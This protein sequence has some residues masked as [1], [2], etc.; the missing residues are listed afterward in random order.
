MKVNES[1]VSAKTVGIPFRDRQALL[2]ITESSTRGAT[3]SH[4]EEDMS[5]SHTMSDHSH[6]GRRETCTLRTTFQ[7]SMDTYA[8]NSFGSSATK[9]AL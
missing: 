9:P 4:C 8:R 1:P 6:S 2:S 3:R 5:N 7:V